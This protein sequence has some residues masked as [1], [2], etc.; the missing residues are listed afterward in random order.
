MP[1]KS[2]L[3]TYGN[4]PCVLIAKRMKAKTQKIIKSKKVNRLFNRLPI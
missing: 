3:I 4:K 2:Y 1:N